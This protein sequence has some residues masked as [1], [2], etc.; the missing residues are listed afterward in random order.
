[1]N[2][3]FR[4]LVARSRRPPGLDAPEGWPPGHFYSPVPDLREIRRR[5]DLIF[6]DPPRRLPGIDLNEAGQLA[7]FG[8]LADLYPSR[9]FARFSL[10]NPNFTTEAIVL[11]CL[12]RHLCPRRVVEIGSGHSS[13]AVL[14]TS[15][16]FLD[17]SVAC[18]FVEPYPDLL[19]SLLLPGDEARIE[20]LEI[21]AQDLPT[22]RVAGIEA[23]DILLIDSTHVLKVDS[24]VTHALFRLLPSLAAGVH[25]HFHDVP[26]PFEY[27]QQWV[28]E[29]RAWNEAYALRAFLQHNDA[30]EVAFFNSFF[31]RFRAAE[32]ERHMPDCSPYAGS[33]LWLRRVAV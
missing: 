3:A 16:L 10:E 33:S 13:C 12:M 1:M 11:Q 20:I 9:R 5:S 15:E 23:G 18:T 6:A 14:D 25:V 29:G 28:F 21:G 22:E 26:Y 7:L 19:R 8:E 4:R 17:G 31:A 2:E 27:P 30:W 32:L 24:D